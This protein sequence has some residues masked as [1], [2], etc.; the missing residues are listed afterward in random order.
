MGI[1]VS[2]L[3]EKGEYKLMERISQRDIQIILRELSEKGFI[4]KD[5]IPFETP[6]QHVVEML[7]DNIKQQGEEALDAF[8]DAL[9]CG[10][11]QE[12]KRWK[13][14]KE[15]IWHNRW[16]LEGKGNINTCIQCVK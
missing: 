2:K 8:I 4:P 6:L 9:R 15:E 1:L 11:V 5:I 12:A 13:N 10:N 7:M 3:I 16:T 14:M